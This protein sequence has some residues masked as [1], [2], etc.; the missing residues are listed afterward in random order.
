MSSTTS[1]A[2][3]RFDIAVAYFMRSMVALLTR[4]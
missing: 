2:L 1:N 3:P 4:F